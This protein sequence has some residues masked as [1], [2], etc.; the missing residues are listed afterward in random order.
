MDCPNRNLFCYVCGLHTPPDKS[1]FITKT[2]VKGFEKFFIMPFLP[3]KWYAPEKICDYCRRSLS[4]IASDDKRHPLKYVT[5]TIW[6]T[7]LD[8]SINTCY[9]CLSREQSIGFRY[10]TREQ[11]KHAIVEEVIPAKLRSE[12]CPLSPYEMEIQLREEDEQEERQRQ[13]Q[14]MEYMDYTEDDMNVG[15]A[16]ETVESSTHKTGESASE[17]LPSTSKQNVAK[18][19]KVHFITQADFNDLVRDSRISQYSAEMWASRLQEWN[20]VAN[21]FKV[22]AGRKRSL[23]ENFDQCF[24]LHEESKIIYCNDIEKLFENFNHPY[25]PNDWRLFIDG[26]VESLKGVLLHIGNIHPSVPIIYGKHAKENYNTMQLIFQLIKYDTHR[27]RVCSDLKIVAILKGIKQGFSK[28]QCFLCDWEGRK[29]ELHY[30]NHKW[31][32]RDDHEIGKLSIER[33]SLVHSTKIILPPLHIKLG[34][35]RNFVRALNKETRQYA[36]IKTIFPRLSDAKIEAG[37]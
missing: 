36:Y 35:M 10:E 6:L 2:V 21:D 11:M 13:Q 32:P 18:V 3:N 37:N 30:S 5:P 27:W 9:F 28:H 22:T 19:K 24:S 31:T 26:S 17:Y 15:T 29:T 1:R 33:D 34:L 20:V 12:N 25:D 14:P 16:S 8:H 4:A 23:V 7:V